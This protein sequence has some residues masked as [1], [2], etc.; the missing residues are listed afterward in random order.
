MKVAIK[1]FGCKVNAYESEYIRRLLEKN[2][3]IIVEENAD[4]YVINT[5]TVTNTSDNKCRKYMRKIR[6][7]H[8][9][10]MLVVMGCTLENTK[11][12]LKDIDAD[13]IIGNKDKSKI[14]DYINEFLINKNQIVKFYDISKE[15]FEDMNIDKFE[16]KT[17]AF[18]KIE[19]GCN[20][21]CSYC[22]IPYVRGRVRSKKASDVI[23]EVT[24]LVKNGHK[25]IVL[26]GIHTGQYKDNDITLSILLEKLLDIKGLYRLRLSSIEITE[27][28]DK[29]LEM[30]KENKIIANHFHIPLQSGSNKVLKEMNRKYDTA[31]FKE[32]VDKLRQIN[33]FVSITTDVIVGFPTESEKDFIDSYNFC[34]EIN[35]S[36]IHVF[37]YSKRD[38]TKAASFA[39]IVNN[40]EKKDRTKKMLELS[41]ELE[42]EFLKKFINKTET[43]IIEEYKNGYFI[44]HTSNYI[45]VYVKEKVN[46]NEI[47][48][49]KLKNIYKDGILGNIII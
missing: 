31:Y 32:V 27:L 3:F 2:D 19:D 36:K 43:I 5:C 42:K 41:M 8:R 47:Y 15:D 23:K 11:D 10:A 35:F 16:T 39:N 45:K 14:I 20:N 7:E 13:I 33:P 37:P 49:V 48:N 38:N 46:L 26:T 21:F 28:N 17:R 25:E 34:K 22:I 29:I 4:I 18:V 6:R 30:F 12:N 40:K 24:S 44:G 1:N 9:D